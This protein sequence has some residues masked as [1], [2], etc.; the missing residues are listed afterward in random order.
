ML[1]PTLNSSYLWEVLGVL[2]KLGLVILLIV[3]FMSLLRRFKM[4]GLGQQTH[5]LA[6]VETL[7]L[8]PKQ[9]VHLVRAGEKVFLVG[10]T[11]ETLSLLSEVD[12]EI[13]T[14]SPALQSLPNLT[15]AQK[16]LAERLASLHLDRFLP[17]LARNV[18]EKKSPLVEPAEAKSSAG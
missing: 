11:D 15:P 14:T 9:K 12:V 17:A 2:L 13:P 3:A 18:A 1:D 7:Y 5:H 10:A 4:G 16:V 8:S 6:L